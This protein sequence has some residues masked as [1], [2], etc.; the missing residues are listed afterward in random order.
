M[1]K[2]QIANTLLKNTINKYLQGFIKEYIL[3]IEAIEQRK[4]E[5]ETFVRFDNCISYLKEVDFNITDWMLFEIP[6]FYSH[7]FWNTNTK[8]AFDLAV[9]DIGK[10]MPRY[11]DSRANEQNAKTIQEAIE[12]YNTE[13][14]VNAGR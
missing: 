14:Y 2:I 11:L 12:K 3:N 9:W 8:Q 6:I 7:C 5:N 1:E 13:G 10:V 4:C